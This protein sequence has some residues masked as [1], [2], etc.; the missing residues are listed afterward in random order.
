M[1]A[2]NWGEDVLEEDVLLNGQSVTVR[3][4]SPL[5][6]TNRYD[7]RLKDKDGDTYTMRNIL[8]TNNKVITFNFSDLD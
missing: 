8:V 1:T 6:R 3:L 5:S 7:I 2:R 4:P